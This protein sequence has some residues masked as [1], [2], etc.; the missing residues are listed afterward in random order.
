M[1]SVEEYARLGRGERIA[2][3]T[4]TAGELQELLTTVGTASLS[5][6]PAAH[7]WA[8]IEVICHLRD[9]EEW[10]FTR[11][12]WA[13]AMDEPAFPR[14]SPDRWAIERQYLR[15]DCLDALAAFRRHRDD[16]IALFRG[17]SDDQWGRGGVHLDGRGRRTIDEF[18]SVIAWHDDNH[19][20]QLK[21][22]LDGHA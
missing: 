15:N 17:L 5:L 16:V 21:R 19:L 9:S 20:D 12:Q 2:R 1:P 18:L 4:R 10:F 22:A 11:M 3:L 13:L 6:R 7:A 8:P 14:N